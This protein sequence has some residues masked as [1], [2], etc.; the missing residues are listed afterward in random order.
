MGKSFLI[1]SIGKKLKKIKYLKYYEKLKYY[2]VKKKN[3]VPFVLWFFKILNYLIIP[4][5]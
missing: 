2:L 3:V 4:K 1:R 5:K